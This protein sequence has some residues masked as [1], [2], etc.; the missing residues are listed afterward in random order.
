MYMHKHK[1]KKK[2]L[3][4]KEHLSEVWSNHQ[5]NMHVMLR[6]NCHAPLVLVALTIKLS[7]FCL[8]CPIGVAAAN[9]LSF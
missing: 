9:S 7:T 6:G 2:K 5:L 1:K 8:N 4:A 3:W